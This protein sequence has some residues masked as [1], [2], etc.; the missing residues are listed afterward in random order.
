L[1]CFFFYDMDR[2]ETAAV[3][4]PGGSRR[5]CGGRQLSMLFWVGGS[6][7]VMLLRESGLDDEE[8]E[9]GGIDVGGMLGRRRSK[10]DDRGA[11]LFSGRSAPITWSGASV[12]EDVEEGPAV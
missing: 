3:C 6:V 10:L 1:I 5:I 7:L 4:L 12:V 2:T 11:V 8:V 9:L